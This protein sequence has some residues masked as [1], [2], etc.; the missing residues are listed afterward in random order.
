VE[1]SLTLLAQ[2][3]AADADCRT[4][5]PE[6]ARELASVLGRLGKGPIA[7][8]I[9]H[10]TSGKEGP[11]EFSRA[12]FLATMLGLL[13]NVGSARQA[14]EL[15]HQAA[16]NDF[17]PLA[18]MAVD[19][20]R[21]FETSIAAGM[22]LSV[23]CGENPDGAVGPDELAPACAKW[24]RTDPG[25]V[26][27]GPV[28]SSVPVLLISGYLDPITPP[29]GAAEIA[30]HLPNSLHLVIRNG[31]H[32]YT[33]LSPCLDGIMASFIE[34]ASVNGLDT[35]CVGSIRRPA[36]GGTGSR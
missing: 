36:F 8:T 16:G 28:R 35:A 24:P 6:L 22:A 31:S 5:Y 11:A 12:T 21:G 9:T 23:F 18:R 29:S 33:G 10:P 13:Q 25:P 19:D 20:H 3:C 17:T 15:I 4:T 7:V 32:S 30:K 2:D 14:L 34:Q 1:R 27:E 26:D